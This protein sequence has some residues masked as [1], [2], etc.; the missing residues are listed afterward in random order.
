MKNNLGYSLVGVLVTSVIGSIVALG[1]THMLVQSKLNS[2]VMEKREQRRKIYGYINNFLSDSQSCLNTL[3]HHDLSGTN[4]KVTDSPQKDIV[5]HFD[6]PALK[7]AAGTTIM[8]FSKNTA[9]ELT[10]AETKKKLKSLGIDEFV[11]LKFKTNPLK[12]GWS[13]GRV[14]LVSQTNIPGMH[15]KDNPSVTWEM[16]G[17]K[18]EDLSG[19][20]PN[21]GDQV[22]LCP[23]T[24]PL[25][26]LCGKNVTGTGHDNG[27]GFV[28]NTARVDSGVYVA[29]S[30]VVCGTAKVKGNAKVFG[31]ALVKDNAEV[32]D[33]AL[34]YDNAKVYGNAV[35]QDNARIFDNAKVYGNAK[36]KDDAKISGMSQVYGSAEVKDDVQI[37]DQ[38]KVYGKAVIRGDAEIS[39]GAK[40]SG[41]SAV[42]GHAKIMD[43]ARVGSHSGTPGTAKAYVYGH[44]KLFHNSSVFASSD[45]VHG[46][47]AYGYTEL[48]GFGYLSHNAKAYG[49]SRVAGGISHNGQIYGNA[50]LVNGRIADNAKAYGNSSIHNGSW[51]S[52]NGQLG[53]DVIL[54]RGHINDNCVCA[55][56]APAGKYIKLHQVCEAPR[57]T[58]QGQL[59]EV[60]K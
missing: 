15:Q 24:S 28:E 42:S 5:R 20:D 38:A 18:I 34:V 32:K 19:S 56:I 49:N 7:D 41:Q 22:T 50:R 30:S 9:G 59:S 29:D 53:G 55:E 45:S 31:N 10:H 12:D 21:K 16:S 36:I 43:N 48:T 8:D 2:A 26:I 33:N 39:G 52:H 57:T 37:L 44:A 4:I 40:V 35:I 46:P 6:I 14:I 13:A 17:M 51:M 3:Q 1:T 25:K 47:Q 27:G 23:N 54:S 60:S 58:C 11:S